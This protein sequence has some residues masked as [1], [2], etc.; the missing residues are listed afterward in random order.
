M[1]RLPHIL[2]T[3]ILILSTTSCSVDKY[4]QPGEKWLYE[5]RINISMADSSAVTPEV[6]EALA[7]AKQYFHQ[8]PNRRILWMPLS[9]RLYCL[10]N[11][12]KDNWFNNL[13]RSNGEPP[14]VYDRN[15]AQRTATQLTTLL[16]T[17]GCFNSTVTTDTL[18]RDATSV[19]VNYNITATQ[20]RKID[21]LEFRSR[22]KDINDL[23]QQW[24]STSLLKVGDYYDQQKMTA[25]QSRI[26]TNLKNEGYYYASAEAV[27]FLVDTTYD[28]RSLSIT[29]VVRHPQSQPRDSAT[30]YTL[31]KYH[32]DNIYIYPNISTAPDPRHSHFDTLVYP[33]NNRRGT[34][35][36]FFIYDKKI[37]PSPKTISRSMFLFNGMTY[38]PRFVSSTSNSLLGLHNFKYVDISFVESPNS[39]DTNRLLDAHIRL[40]NSP[41]HRLSLSFELTNASN[42][43]NKESNFFTSGNLGLGTTLGYQYNNLFGGAEMLNI[44]GN[45][46]FDLPKNVF[47]SSNRDFHSTFSSFEMGVNTSLDL[48]DFLMPFAQSTIWQSSKPH[49]L[50]EFNTNYLYRNLTLPNYGGQDLDITLERLRFGGS[51]GYTWNHNRNTKHKL[52]P[53]NLSYSHLLSGSEYYLYLS[54]I[55]ADPQF[56]YQAFDYILLNT[57]YEYTIS[58]QN[59]GTR[60]N[61]NYLRLSVETA[62]NLLNAVDRLIY[63]PQQTTNDD[64]V[65]YYQY[66]RFDSEFKR[67]IYWGNKSTLVLRTLVGLCIPY[68]HSSFIPYEKMFVGG[69]PT[70]MRGW[71]LRRLGYGQYLSSQTDIA[72]GTGD[73]QL[74]ANV[75]QRFPIIG[76][77]EG[78]LFADAGNVWMCEDWGIGTSNPFQLSEIAR[79]IALDAGIG[80]R[81]NISVVTL[82]VDL[83]LP[84]YD[85]G[86]LAGQRWLP[87]HWAWNKISTHF[88][89][90]YPF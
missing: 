29:V 6:S 16:K 54:S 73:I 71:A 37:S 86:Y 61:F 64:N 15:A 57:H 10:S 55:T 90:N 45:L 26:I 44:E 72:M 67:Y 87:S 38:R 21:D 82:R 9:M 48:P 28:S 43:S 78:A 58:N 70:T 52:L 85:P 62:G 22:Q 88:G 81:A 35:D 39:I 14:V 89:I 2:L 18:H 80:I 41:R 84:L 60:D 49:T 77:F 31:Q 74:I 46:L 69:G 68:G 5:N 13:L 17:N 3:A 83:A 24:K 66:F 23:L 56:L 12:G 75:E 34:T 32:I 63:G 76:I 51:F 40:L 53:I 59:I 25:E 30:G 36:Y 7:E 19:T 11:P 47:T 50:V 27:R 4:L 42:F 79:G 1:K 33:Y 65:Q 8:S 20:R